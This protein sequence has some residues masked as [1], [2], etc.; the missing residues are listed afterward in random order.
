WRRLVTDDPT[1]AERQARSLADLLSVL[2][3]QRLGTATITV[4]GI[5]DTAN[6][7][8]SQADVYVADSLVQPHHRVYGGQVLAQS[9]MAASLTVREEFPQR[10]PHSLHAYFMR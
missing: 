4:S 5:D 7:S 1:P 8:S 3:L 10:L 6:V 9:L 2:D